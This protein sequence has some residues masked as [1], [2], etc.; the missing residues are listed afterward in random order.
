M[1]D[2]VITL[3]SYTLK[4]CRQCFAGDTISI[5]QKYSANLAFNNLPWIWIIPSYQSPPLS[6]WFPPSLVPQQRL[7]DW[8]LQVPPLCLWCLYHAL[9]LSSGPCSL[10]LW[11]LLPTL[12]DFLCLPDSLECLL[13]PFV[14]FKI[15]LNNGGFAISYILYFH[16]IIISQ[17]HFRK[18]T[19]CLEQERG[20]SKK[21]F[22]QGDCWDFKMHS[23]NIWIAQ[24]FKK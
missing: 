22:Q 18:K 5:T 24:I 19:M 4:A 14:S 16:T 2:K 17:F 9:T 12:A 15:I 8:Q 11:S 3:C 10:P 6:L 23:L 20:N 13:W 21:V 1:L 7:S